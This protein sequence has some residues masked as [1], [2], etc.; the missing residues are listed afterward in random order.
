MRS[1]RSLSLPDLLAECQALDGFR[2]TSGNLYE[3]VRALFF[4]YAIHRFHI[5]LH[6][7]AAAPAAIPFAGY[8]NLLKRRFEE[9]IDIF[10]AAQ[11]PRAGRGDLQR[12][13]AAYRG[14]AFRRWPDRCATACARCAAT[15]GCSASAIRPTTRCG[16]AGT[17]ARRR[18]PVPA[19]ARIHARPH[20]P[21]AQRMERH[22]FPGHGFSRR[23][24]RDQYLGGSGGARRRGGRAPSRRWKRTCAS[25]TSRCCAW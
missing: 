14:W 22:L 12:A 15:S 23:R 18:R 1:A 9:A 4:L 8:T 2:R 6:D 19:A 16:C 5:P 17:A 3:R 25:S 13:G 21:D 7:R 20:G 10:L 11:P 24:A